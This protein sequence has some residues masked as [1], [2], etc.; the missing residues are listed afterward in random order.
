MQIP[1]ECFRYSS[2][3]EQI[4]QEG[5]LFIEVEGLNCEEEIQIEIKDSQFPFKTFVSGETLFYTNIV[6][7]LFAENARI[8]LSWRFIPALILSLLS[9]K[10]THKLLYVFN[11]I[12]F[13]VLSPYL[14]KDRHLTKFSQELEWATFTFLFNL[15][16]QEDYA[17]RFAEIFVHLL[18]HD[19]A[20]RLRI[21]DLF[22]ETTIEKLHKPKEIR[23]LAKLSFERNNKVAWSSK[24]KNLMIICSLILYVPKIRKAYK[25]VLKDLNL[26]NLQ[27]DEKDMY[28]SVFKEDYNLMGMT[29]DERKEYAKSQGWHYPK[30]WTQN[31]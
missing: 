15:G 8:L 11:R 23:R 9:R 13:R 30:V 4:K 25:T 14:L 1:R 10:M 28:W 24:Y 19:D 6:K 7:S 12:G 2:P 17:S 29:A 3:E 27:L 16:I 22:T 5:K 31:T 20:H 26:K 18:E 21:Q